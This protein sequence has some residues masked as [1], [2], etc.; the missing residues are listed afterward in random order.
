MANRRQIGP[1]KPPKAEQRPLPKE[2]PSNSLDRF[3]AGLIGDP[4]PGDEV[5][6]SLGERLPYAAGSIAPA[7]VLGKLMKAL[8]LRVPKQPTS[9]PSTPSNVADAALRQHELEKLLPRE[10][11][12]VGSEPPYTRPV[13]KDP[14]DLGYE[15]VKSGTPQRRQLFS[16]RKLD[17]PPSDTV[18]DPEALKILEEFLKNKK[19]LE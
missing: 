12:P 17:P 4:F 16:G 11:T 5:G 6:S 1:T 14:A 3:L 10:F 15:A 13:F 7:G 8:R 18:P 2:G 9:A 19:G